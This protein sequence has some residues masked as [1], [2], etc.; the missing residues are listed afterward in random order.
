MGGI[1]NVMG[2]SVNVI[3]EREMIGLMKSYLRN[4]CMNIVYM[5]SVGT[6]QGIA[7]DSE[8][9]EAMNESKLILPAEKIILS[10]KRS[11]KIRGVVNSYKY[12]LYMLRNKDMAKK[13]YVIGK[14]EKLTESLT[15]ILVQQ[16]TDIEVA[17]MYSMD[18]GYDDE[19]V[20]NE[21]NA[22]EADL[23]VVALDSPELESWIENNKSIIYTKL[24]VGLGDIAENIVKQNGKPPAWV[25]KLHLENI[26]YEIMQRKYSESRRKERI[27][28]TLLAEYNSKRE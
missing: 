18:M 6:L 3:T 21:I 22:A 16:N 1:V 24:C 10:K 5:I 20:I 15:E 28:K 14:T 2:L 7:N 12:F 26:R 11:H 8:L 23:L 25:K 19:T 9:I 17:G 4:D 27:L 13:M